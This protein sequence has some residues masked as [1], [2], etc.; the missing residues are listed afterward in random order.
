M[1]LNF[2]GMKT[3]LIFFLSGAIVAL[4]QPAWVP[5]LAPLASMVGYALFWTLARGL[6]SFQSRLF[7]GW[8]WF[9]G[10]QL[11]QLSWMSCTEYQGVYILF[12]YAV[13]AITIGLQFGILTGGVCRFHPLIL[14]SLWTLMEWLR[15]Y[16]FCG[17]SWN[18]VGLALT[19][20]A[21]PL[22]CASLLGIFGLSFW[23]ILTNGYAFC[24]QWKPFLFCALIPYV[25]GCGQLSYYRSQVEKAST[26][27][28][29]LVQTAL[30]PSQ[31][32]YFPAKQEDFIHPEEQ[33]KQII[34]LLAQHQIP[35]DLIVMPESA[36]P[37][38]D[39]LPL[40]SRQRVCHLFKKILNQS[41]PIEEK[42]EKVS[43]Q[44]WVKAIGDV[45]KADVVIG[46]DALEGHAS[47]A[48]SF[49]YSYQR[50][51]LERYDKTVLIPLVEYLPWTRLRSLSAQYGVNQFFTPGTTEKIFSSQVPIATLICYEETFGQLVRRAKKK[52]ACL[53]VN[54]INDNWYPKSQ[55]H[56][57]HFDLIRTHA[58]ACGIPVVR[59]GNSG[60]TGIIDS[61][62]RIVACLD[63]QDQ[64][65]VLVEKVPLFS[66]STLY[67]QVGDLGIV[68]ISAALISFFYIK[69]S[70][71]MPFTRLK[72]F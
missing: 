36:V 25:W 47:Y 26:L 27:T 59:A 21:Y 11:I 48:S 23:V 66:F 24:G 40:F 37:F 18:P 22:Q 57:Q 44:F 29:A 32:N 70:F 49:F 3:A 33:W 5:S 72:R 64:S 19:S 42:E 2:G 4:G 9:T 69:T 54:V 45:F 20:F 6:N 65:H 63:E 43:H 30:L 51:R 46:L 56:R 14:A 15:L 58:V 71:W 7:V 35:V 34:T 53:L 12:V 17:F 67:F 39:S 28:V 10:V 52:G 41:L 8:I 50:Q 38:S 62:G 68:L 16:F 13:I 55:L 60:I 1:S 31:K 61:L